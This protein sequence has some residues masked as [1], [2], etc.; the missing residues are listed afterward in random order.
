M[1]VKNDLAPV[2]DYYQRMLTG[3]RAAQQEG[4]TLAQATV[5]LAVRTNFPALREA[6]PGAW[7]YGKH[8][9]NVKN[10]WRLL[11]EEQPQPLTGPGKDN[12]PTQSAI[13]NRK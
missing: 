3:V 8:D 4:L 9:R 10:L 2:R 7:S 12:S 13:T 5:R 1:L 11:Q 6:P